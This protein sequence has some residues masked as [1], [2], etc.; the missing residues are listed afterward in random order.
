VSSPSERREGHVDLS[1]LTRRDVLVA[2]GAAA[3]AITLAPYWALAATPQGQLTWGIHVS[4]AP[5]WFDPAETPGIITPFM[6]LFALHDAMVKPMPGQPLAPCL[7]ESFSAS[8]DG[9]VY[10]FVLR[11][12]PNFTMVIRSRP[13]TSNTHS[14]VIA[15]HR[16]T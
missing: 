6:V 13:K 9:L 16:T 3:T 1:G 11:K 15:V 4:L 7:T 12:A 2:A 5:T 8:E 14:S 10:E